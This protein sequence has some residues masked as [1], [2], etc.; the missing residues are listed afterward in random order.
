M[1]PTAF[2][3]TRVRVEVRAVIGQGESRI[4]R[5]RSHSGRIRSPSVIIGRQTVIAARRSFARPSPVRP[6]ARPSRAPYSA[7]RIAPSISG[8]ANVNPDSNS[9]FGSTR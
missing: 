4:R 3:D 7:A 2:R 9:R 6:F 1:P 8:N 5:A